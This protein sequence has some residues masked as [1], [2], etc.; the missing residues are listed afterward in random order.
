[1]AQMERDWLGR[2]LAPWL[3]GLGTTDPA[4]AARLSARIGGAE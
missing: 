3:P 2:H 4:L 1:M